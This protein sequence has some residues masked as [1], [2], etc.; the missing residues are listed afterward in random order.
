ME[1]NNIR[2][3]RIGVIGGSQGLG[4]WM[5][6]FFRN[7]GCEVRFTSA[8]A[9][10]EFASNR[11]L[12]AF[13]DVVFFCVPISKMVEVFSECYP[14]LDGKTVVE[15]CSVKKFIIDHVATLRAQHAEVRC[16][17]YS[18][19]PMF[20]QKQNNLKGQVVI[21]N[22][23]HNGDA[24]FLQ[25]LRYHFERHGAVWYELAYEEH[26]RLMGLVQGLNHF[27][28]FVSSKTLQ[29]AG[30]ELEAIKAFSS[31]PY[32]IFVVFFTRYML[33]NPQ[34]YAEI[35]L[36]NEYVLN[37]LRIFKEEVDRLYNLIA[38]K[39]EEGFIAYVREMQPFFESNVLDRTI[40]N[41][42]VEQLGISLAEHA[43]RTSKNST[44]IG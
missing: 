40:S 31:P 8:D 14:Y 43:E 7:E 27:N 6:G 23:T 38:N 13:A 22:Y 16:A 25:T 26:D 21:E 39:D 33:Q 5:V 18:L 17:F 36:F 4:S 30:F 24:N 19:H 15:I 12:I 3:R 10:S 20:S 37:T 2:S 44:H 34:L 28:V 35:Q 42:L 11:E 41:H 1:L 32:R 9:L 29:R